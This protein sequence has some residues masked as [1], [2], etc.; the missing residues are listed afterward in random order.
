MADGTSSW[1]AVLARLDDAAALVG[2]DADVHAILR[3][4]TRVLEVAVPIKRD[5][6]HIEVFTGWRVHHNVTRGPAKGGIRFHPAVDALEVTALAAEMT[7]KTAVLEL[8]FGGG[9]GGVRCDPSTL[10]VHELER[11]TRR[12]T[13]EIL[14]LLGPDTDVPAPDVNTDE[15]V[16][17]WLMDTASM[18]SGRSLPAAVTGKPLALQGSFGHSGAT[19]SGLLT[20]V[21]LAFAELG[22]SLAGGR[23]VV[24]GFG[25][26]GGALAFL[27]H[28]AGMRVVGVGDIGGAIANP[29]GLD[30][31]AL[32]THV[33]EHGSVVGFPIA[34]PVDAAELFAL[35]CDVVIPAALANA[36]DERI[37]ATLHA[38]LVVEGANGPT[39]PAADAV[40][41]DRGI[42]VVPDILANGGGVTASYFEWAQNR[43]GYAWDENVVA[44]RLQRRMEK[45]FAEVWARAQV[46]ETELRRAALAV[47]I[48]RVAAA[49]HARG[50]FP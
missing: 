10:S 8:P 47:A 48:E 46:L 14:P 33:R 37:A 17:G 24:Q 18:A 32:S 11:L 40:L 19:A 15:R 41:H 45:A 4:P 25:K 1:E 9:K 7:F 44:E 35:P 31:P 22:L 6:G 12:Y 13:W 5:A 27:L 16:M 50:L 34:D 2:L 36:I 38:T 21:R 30:I 20:C 28:S 49:F 29:A 39:T 23:A 26:V 43:Q 42:K 3:T